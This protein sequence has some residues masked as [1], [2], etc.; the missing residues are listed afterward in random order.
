MSKLLELNGGLRLLYKSS[1]VVGV[2]K[3]AELA[4]CQQERQREQ[5]LTSIQGTGLCEKTC[6]APKP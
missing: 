4:S 1:T 3:E 6:T 5:S 2:S